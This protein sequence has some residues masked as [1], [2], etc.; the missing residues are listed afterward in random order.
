MAV[1]GKP[2]VISLELTELDVTIL[3]EAL[4]AHEITQLERRAS[5]KA[6]RILIDRIYRKLGVRL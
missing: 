3:L 2:K 1:V 5:T 4:G 6:T